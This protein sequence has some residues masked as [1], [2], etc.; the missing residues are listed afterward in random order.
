[1]KKLIAILLIAAGTALTGC[2]SSSMV[3]EYSNPLTGKTEFVDTI[4]HATRKE[5]AKIFTWTM[6][7]TLIIVQIFVILL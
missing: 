5:N 7:N 6:A 2:K 3:R 1:M 4:E